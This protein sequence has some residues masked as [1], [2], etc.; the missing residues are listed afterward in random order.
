MARIARVVVPNYP[1]HVTQRGNRRQRVFFS[2]EDYQY[3]IQLM[4]KAKE[5]AAV[6]IWAYCLMP[7]HVHFVVVPKESDSLARL[8]QEAHKQYTRRINFRFGWRG[9]LWQERFHSF[10][11][12][13]TYLLRTVRYVE[14]NPVRAGFYQT[15]GEWEW[16]SAN[17]HLQGKDD[18]LALV[19]PMLSRIKNWTEYLAVDESLEHLESIR[20]F[21]RTGRPAGPDQ[22]IDSLESLIGR[23][24]RLKKVGRKK[25]FSG[26]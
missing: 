22:F 25:K 5:S 23:D 2:S 12:D 18:H 10:V 7:N 3:Y 9:H 11:M 17:A 6:E 19:K 21:S 8:F 14:L 16:S 26:N 15:P 4:A 1:H 13:E 20:R 24:L